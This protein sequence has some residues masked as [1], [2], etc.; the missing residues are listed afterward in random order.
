MSN[1]WRKR[2]NKPNPFL[3]AQAQESSDK[4][5]AE[6]SR[7]NPEFA[8]QH[9][10]NGSTSHRNPY[11]DDT[12]HDAQHEFGPD[13]NT[14][15]IADHKV[16]RSNHTKHQVV[17]DQNGY[18]VQSNGNSHPDHT[19]KHHSHS[20]HN[21]D[22]TSDAKSHSTHYAQGRVRDL[23]SAAEHKDT[24]TVRNDNPYHPSNFYTES[25]DRDTAKGLISN[26]RKYPKAVVPKKRGRHN[27]HRQH[28]GHS[29]GNEED[30][31]AADAD[32]DEM[33]GFF[34]SIEL[35][36][37]AANEEQQYHH[38]FCHQEFGHNEFQEEEEKTDDDAS[39][40]EHF[41]QFM[42][43]LDAESC[44][45]RRS[46]SSNCIDGCERIT[47]SNFETMKKG[48]IVS[49]LME[50][51]WTYYKVVSN[52][53]NG[54]DFVAK[55]ESGFASKEESVFI[56]DGVI[57]QF[58]T[59]WGEQTADQMAICRETSSTEHEVA[60][61][62]IVENGWVKLEEDGYSKLHLVVAYEA[63]SGKALLKAM[64]SKVERTVDLN[65]CAY[66]VL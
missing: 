6:I 59:V 63:S 26:H 27:G 10:S 9:R 25:D 29:N 31:E 1:S 15:F 32:M 53:R 38:D 37:G 4:T 30:L 54:D 46:G 33:E 36:D 44:S 60:V 19:H 11:V 23:Q 8:T 16:K 13:A 35:N 61:L 43:D 20:A 48:D 34:Q 45:P 49:I 65:E 62:D 41:R 18:H 14:Q 47:P 55:F 51:L 42:A 40:D 39:Q 3:S 28:N 64:G 5:L 52:E 22:G 7:V 17:G 21:Q 66:R 2:D 56:K 24:V 58:V 57:S 12:L 50:N